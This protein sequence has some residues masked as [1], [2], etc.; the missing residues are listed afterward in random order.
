MKAY[1]H[2]HLLAGMAGR[3]LREV[4]QRG[5]GASVRVGKACG[6]AAG[7]VRVVVVIV[8]DGQDT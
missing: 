4:R 8:S 3:R 2:L 5:D 6:A 7:V 1:A